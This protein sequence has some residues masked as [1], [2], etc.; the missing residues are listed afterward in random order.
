MNEEI[1]IKVI[2]ENLGETH[3]ILK[4]AT[5]R[6]LER[7]NTVDQ[8]E[9]QA[10]ALLDSSEEFWHGTLP[11]WKRYIYSWKPPHWWWWRCCGRCCK[12]KRIRH[13]V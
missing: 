10:D 11:G 7:G 12:K 9:D 2:Q 6:L 8:T 13:D 1:Q 4:S 5:N 3:A